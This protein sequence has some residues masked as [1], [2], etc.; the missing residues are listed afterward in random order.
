[1]TL[2][3]INNDGRDSNGNSNTTE[4]R[5]IMYSRHLQTLRYRKNL[6]HNFTNFVKVLKEDSLLVSED[7]FSDEFGILNS[8]EAFFNFA[9]YSFSDLVQDLM[10][11][12]SVSSN[13]LY[14]FRT[15]LYK[16]R[17]K[18]E[19][20]Y[21]SMSKNLSDIYCRTSKYR[22]NSD[23]VKSYYKHL[24]NIIT[25]LKAIK[26]V[27]YSKKK[28]GIYRAW[29]KD[30]YD[31]NLRYYPDFLLEKWYKYQPSI[32]IYERMYNPTKDLTISITS[33]S[34]KFIVGI[35]KNL[36]T[37]VSDVQ[38]KVFEISKSNY[39]YLTNEIIFSKEPLIE[40]SENNEND[41]IS[42][43]ISK[44]ILINDVKKFNA[45]IEEIT[46]LIIS[47]KIK[48][49]AIY[50]YEKTKENS[51]YVKDNLLEKYRRFLSSGSSNEKN[52]NKIDESCEKE[53]V[54]CS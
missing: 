40:I 46:R 19:F 7:N 31:H 16:N 45:F 30:S 53:L 22:F 13:L 10:L 25:D 29:V 18:L 15:I 27:K 48:E 54:S 42:I 28:L 38:K 4:E 14:K 5:Y 49:N 50:L 52:K 3:K 21:S 17:E 37:Y 51:L 34:L 23:S 9:M 39:F 2:N 36:S 1:M 12:T 35:S 24:G 11:F 33:N 43:K 20:L 44:K 41:S 32:Y 8:S 47:I 6:E 26:I